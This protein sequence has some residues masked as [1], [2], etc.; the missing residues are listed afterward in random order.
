M[1]TKKLKLGTIIFTGILSTALIAGCAVTKSTEDDTETTLPSN[2]EAITEESESNSGSPSAE[3]VY[4]IQIEYYEKLIA[5][6]EDKL[7][8]SREESFIE[9]S[10][11]KETIAELEESIKQLEGKLE[12]IMN[13]DTP[14]A[15][16]PKDTLENSNQSQSDKAEPTPTQK[17]EVT[18]PP[19]SPS[20]MTQGSPFEYEIKGGEI[21]IIGY[22][23]KDISVTIP[24]N[25]NG[26]PV[27][28]IGEG[29]FRDAKIQRITLPDGIK[30][31]DWFA[32]STCSALCEIVIP[33]SV[34]S[35]G[36]GAFDGCSGFLVIR[37]ESGSY[38]EAFATSWGI[39]SITK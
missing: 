20:E 25:I 15:Q 28:A 39:L 18:P 10:Q 36:Y 6:L 32:F 11:Y 14:T 30:R 24:S 21:T 5:E 9:S 26:I 34:V 35:I 17:E 29:A 12:E 13:A 7:L 8:E 2:L 27:T 22:K 37:C 33:S 38:A 4:L 1:K 19:S 31:I 16:P 3:S 23:G